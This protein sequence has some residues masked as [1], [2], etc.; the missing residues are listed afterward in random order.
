MYVSGVSWNWAYLV[1]AICLVEIG[2]NGK[3]LRRWW[4]D[5]A[6]RDILVGCR[7]LLNSGVLLVNLNIRHF[8]IWIGDWQEH[9]DRA[10]LF[11]CSVGRSGRKWRGGYY[12]VPR[13]R[14]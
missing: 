9:Y 11:F 5:P 2:R 6:T 12:L 13:G 4:G 10:K 7:C 8:V 14:R 1:T 3:E